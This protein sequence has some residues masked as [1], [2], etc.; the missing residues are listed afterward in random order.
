LCAKMFRVNK[1]LNKQLLYLII[2][3]ASLRQMDI[4]LKCNMNRQEKLY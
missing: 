3:Q 4:I 2:R 1:A